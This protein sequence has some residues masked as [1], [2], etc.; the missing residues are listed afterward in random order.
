MKNIYD[1]SVLCLLP[2]GDVLRKPASYIH[3]RKS[4]DTLHTV[5]QGQTL[6]TISLIKYGDVRYWSNIARANN[7]IDPFKDLTGKQIIIPS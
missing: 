4:T 2:S 7:I 6:H 3:K 5:K 1:D